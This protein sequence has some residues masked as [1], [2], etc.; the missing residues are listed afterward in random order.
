MQMPLAIPLE[1]LEGKPQSGPQHAINASRRQAPCFFCFCFIF[2]FIFIIF[3]FSK[4]L[5]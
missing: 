1:E 3:S 2:I 4:D 5:K